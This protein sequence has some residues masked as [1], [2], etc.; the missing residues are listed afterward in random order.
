MFSDAEFGDLN[1]ERTG[2][3]DRSGECTMGR[4]KRL[5]IGCGSG[6]VIDGPF[7]DRHAFAGDRGLV[8]AGLTGGHEAVCRDSLVRF[9]DDDIAH[10]Q[11]FDGNF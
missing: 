10:D 3:I 2:L 1:F 9:D 6:N 4:R 5:G 8:D 11:V 7:V